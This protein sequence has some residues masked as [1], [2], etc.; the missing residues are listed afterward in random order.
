MLESWQ[1]VA[2]TTSKKCGDDGIAQQKGEMDI[3][4]NINSQAA[5]QL[6]NYSLEPFGKCYRGL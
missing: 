1:C 3:Q 4:K 5:L 6:R 2:T